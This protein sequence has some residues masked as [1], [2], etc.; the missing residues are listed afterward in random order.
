MFGRL[1]KLLLTTTALVP[2]G[3]APA[4]AN[5]LGPQVV[6]GNATVQGQGTAAVTVTQQTNSAIINWNTFNIGIGEKTKIVMPSSSSVELDRVTGGLGPSQILG[7][8]WSNGRVFLVNPDGI[9]FGSGAK[10]DT[11]GF[12]ATT[13]DIKNND[14]MAGRY[15]FS[16]PGRPDASVVNQGTITAQTGGFAALVAPGVRNSGTITATLGTVALASGN[17]FT[18]DFYG[19][20]LITLGLNDAIAATVKDVAT[21]QTLSALVKN[22]GTLKADGGRVELTAVAARQVVDSVINTTGVIEANSI[23]THNGMIVLGAATAATKPA[24]AVTQTVKVSGTLSAAGKKKGTT[25]GTVVVTGENIVVSGAT[26]DAFGAAGGGKVL[27]GGDVRGG[28]PNPAVA[29]IPQAQLQPYAVPTAST[30]TVDAATTINASATD[31][32]NGGKVVVWADH[33]TLFDGSISVRGGATFGNGGFVE[34]SGHQQL[35][36]NG[37][38]DTGAPNG[39]HGTLLLDPQDVT[40]GSTGAW[41]ITPS[42]LESALASSN[43]FV[44]TDATLAGSGDITITQSFGWANNTALSLAAYR[45]III[46]NGVTISVSGAHGYLFLGAGISGEPVPGAIPVATGMG[47]VIFNGSSKIDLSGGGSTSVIFYNPPFGYGN[48]TN[49]NSHYIFNSVQTSADADMLIN[50]V[51]DLQHIV[52]SQNNVYVLNS[53][54]SLAT[55]HSACPTCS[56]FYIN[57][58]GLSE[59][60][61]SSGWRVFQPTSTSSSTPSVPPATPQINPVSPIPPQPAVSTPP[62]INNLN[63]PTSKTTGTIG[64]PTSPPSDAGTVLSVN[65]T[66]L[67]VAAAGNGGAIEGTLTLQFPGG[68]KATVTSYSNGGNQGTTVGNEAWQCSALIVRYAN[69]LGITGLLSDYSNVLSGKAVA[70]QLASVSNGKFVYLPNGSAVAP[71]VGA[72]IS[73]G[74]FTT[75][76]AKGNTDPAGHVGIVQSVQQNPNG[77]LTL[78]LFDQNWP[79]GAHWSQ[80]T[81]TKQ[82]SSYS[83]TMKDSNAPGGV[84]TVVGWA[85]PASL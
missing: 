55:A 61:P 8:L 49:Y 45:N 46:N 28:N 85:N 54:I 50:T 82:G 83:G 17:G 14:F 52:Y 32:G 47:T 68:S 33:T 10:V 2:L 36:F 69:Q 38:V 9:L 21:G 31:S 29:A 67:V 37:S 81:L 22:E 18:L 34:T 66:P 78:T 76:D 35:A 11:A 74:G 5:P 65:S 64:S 42:A 62:V 27:I 15:N 30:V 13:S 12:L 59:P 23:G 70:K 63:S 60:F 44:G 57:S 71:E 6:S 3:L 39:K 84:L 80:V 75:P 20:K 41:V 25:G 77:S 58:P 43:V 73:I 26:I 79:G 48:P 7:S 53:N 24:G 19:D 4:A 16:I 51:S 56:P 72:V 40:I 1:R